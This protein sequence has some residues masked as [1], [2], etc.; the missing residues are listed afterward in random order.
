MKNA[1]KLLASALAACALVTSG[2]S[3]VLAAE[4]VAV[5]FSKSVAL[6]DMLAG[7]DGEKNVMFSP[8]SLNFA[9]GMLCEGAKGTTKEALNAYLGTAEFS[10]IAADYMEKLPDYNSDD[11]VQFGYKQ[12]LKIANALWADQKKA[13]KPDFLDRVTGK[14]KA[15]LKN[16]DFSRPEQVCDMINEWSDENTEHLI[17]KI[18]SPD[19]VT[20]ADLVLTNSLYFEAPWAKEA[21]TEMEEP[22]K[23][24]GFTEEEDVKYMETSGNQYYENEKATAFSRAYQNGIQFMGILP[25]EEGEFT[26]EELNIDSLLHSE[27][28]YTRVDCVMPAELNFETTSYLK[29]QLTELGLGNVFSDEADFSGISDVPSLVSEI[30]QKTKIELDKNGTK[31]AAVTAIIEECAMELEEEPEVIKEVVLNRPFAF[32][33]YDERNKEVLFMGKIAVPH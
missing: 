12:K 33:I 19:D 21:W 25:K 22:E 2:G 17:P 31:A 27:P 28:E 7:K 32:L 23:F 4:E 13:L 30:I 14:Y 5:N 20:G 8:T 6:T 24:Y 29:E 11:E 15:G 9:L 10:E 16:A 1:K 3:S 26:L 18:V